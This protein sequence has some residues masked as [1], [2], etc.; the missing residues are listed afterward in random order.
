MEW[1]NEDEANVLLD[2]GSACA[3]MFD[4]A[5]HPINCRAFSKASSFQDTCDDNSFPVFNPR[6]SLSYL[7]LF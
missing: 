6:T 3:T 4:C 5:F 1:G 2:C 7:I